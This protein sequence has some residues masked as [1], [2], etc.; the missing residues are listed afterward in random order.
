MLSNNKKYAVGLFLD[1]SEAF[2]TVNHKILLNKLT[3]YGIR[4]VA[5][6]WINSYLD[7]IQ[8]YCSYFD[9]TSS[10]KYIT[11]GVPQ[12][13]ILGPLLFLIYINDLGKIFKHATPILFADDTNLIL[14]GN[15]LNETEHK[16]NEE[17]PLLTNWLYA[18]RL[19]LNIKKPKCDGIWKQTTLWEFNS[20]HFY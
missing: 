12:E 14:T 5:N 10:K 3:H 15:S 19:S 13:S 18:N 20:Q 9:S 16:L 7:H 2:D 8:Q 4:G 1:F 17:I 6:H 11:C